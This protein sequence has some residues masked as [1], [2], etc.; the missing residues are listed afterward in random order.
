MI[1]Q[2]ISHYRIVEKLGGGGMGVVYKA[3]DS[4]LGRFVALKFLPE[5]LAQDPQSLERFRRE[6]RAASALNHPNICT[7]YEIGR[8]GDLSFIAMEYLEGLTLKHRIGGKAMEIDTVLWLG[9]EIADALDA[10][11]S[12]GI[13]HRDIKPANVFVSK[14]GHAKI[15]DFGLAKILAKPASAG[16]DSLTVS[17]GSDVSQLTSEGALVGTVAYMSPEQVR[18]KELDARSDLFSYGAVL[19][20]MATG[21][22]PFDGASAGEICGAILLQ[23]PVRPSQINAQL[24][25]A[26]EAVILKALEKDYSLRYQ[27]ASELR[28]DLQRVKRDS[29]TGRVP[30]AASGSGSAVREDGT[31]PAKRNLWK[32]AVPS[33][34]VIVAL[35]AGGLYYRS[36]R[37]KPLTDKDTIVLADFTNITG[38][39]VFDDTLKQAL[40]IG[41][42]QSPFLSI[43]PEQKVKYTLSLMGRPPTER[44]TSQTAREVCQRTGSTAVVEGSIS[45]L[46]A[47]YILGLGAVNCRTGDSLAQEQVQ[48]ARKED[49]LKALGQT[50][51]QLRPKLGESLSTVQKYDVPLAEASTSSL[52]ALKAFSLGMSAMNSQE[53]SA[54]VPH[55]QRAI[56]S[57]PNFALAYSQLGMLYASDL[58]EPGLAA[59]NIRRAYELRDRASEAERFNI[60]ANYYTFVTGEAEKGIKTCQSWA[61]A[62][63]R[64]SMP[65]VAIGYMSAYLGRYEDEVKESAE[66]IRLMPSAGHAYPNLME[67]YIAL[68][69]VDE[70]KAV[71]GQALERKTDFQF[72]QDDR[73]DIAF[74][75]GD[76]D[77]MKRQA[78][79]VAGIPGVEDLLLSGQ[80]DTET[81]H[82]RLGKA[83]E[84]TTRAV[85]SALKAEEKETAALWQ[86]SSALGEAEF[87]NVDRAKQ[88]VKRGLAIA[89]TRDVQTLAAL[90]LACSGDAAQ[91]H[92]LAENLQRQFPLNTTL[93]YYWLPVVRAYLALRSGHPDRAIESLE[94]TAPYELAFPLPQ[95]SAGGTL[96][97]PYVRGQAYLALHKGKEAETEFQKLIEHRTMLANFALGSLVHLQLARSFAMQ[98]D[99]ARAKTAYQDFLT[100]WKDADP[101]IPILKQAKAEYA[102]L[103]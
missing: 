92:A 58:Q 76:S 93:N 15:L 72:L 69:R 65:H 44:L 62:Y 21:K 81:F 18:A 25:Q 98:N 31:Q 88:E 68:N 71:Y 73:Y 32:I 78:A 86:L 60:T 9:I 12:A 101:D 33:V 22:A 43:L 20:E 35:I 94:E 59:E 3:E 67:G 63:P 4:E 30:A 103:Q 8:H 37:A 64:D 99:T 52:E 45:S 6:A 29:E 84:L 48:A 54:V 26:L 56:E 90:V 79:A 40:F 77:E 82:G 80:A 27:H 36:H 14:R 24:P 85:N 34:A 39:P 1:G 49:V 11:H 41:L 16:S 91:A 100:L 46:G 95:F 55:L 42:Q 102:K 2:T 19:Y 87:G 96:Y 70:A 97:P 89:S 66:A 28:T 61:Q 83:R 5:A 7:I 47:E 38:D 50:I 17:L 23:E 74:L 13:V 53:T 51:T 75:E 10:A 57:D